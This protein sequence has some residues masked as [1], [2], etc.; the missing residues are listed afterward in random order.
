MKNTPFGAFLGYSHHL[1]SSVIVVGICSNIFYIINLIIFIIT[2]FNE[3]AY[4]SIPDSK[5]NTSFHIFKFHRVR[6]PSFPQ[7]RNFYREYLI[8]MY[9]FINIFFLSSV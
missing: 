3:L 1:R 8:K 4:F 5:Q 9:L 2:V 6:R 7:V